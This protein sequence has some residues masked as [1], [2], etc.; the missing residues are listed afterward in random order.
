MRGLSGSESGK[1]RWSHKRGARHRNEPRVRSDSSVI[2]NSLRA[3]NQRDEQPR[4]GNAGAASAELRAAAASLT[5]SQSS[6]SK[7]SLTHGTRADPV[8]LVLDEP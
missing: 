6:R 8:R 4:P 5:Q 2:V 3:P 7:P 1:C